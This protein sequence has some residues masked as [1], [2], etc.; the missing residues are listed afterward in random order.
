MS[1]WSSVDYKMPVAFGK[2]SCIVKRILNAKMNTK[3]NTQVKGKHS[4][5][6]EYSIYKGA[7]LLILIHFFF[8]KGGPQHGLESDFQKFKESFGNSDLEEK[9]KSLSLWNSIMKE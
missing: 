6:T 7:N 5:T 8:T 4:P 3:V 9:G 1:H 2:I